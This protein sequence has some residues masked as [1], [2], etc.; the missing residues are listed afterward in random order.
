VSDPAEGNGP[1]IEPPSA[2]SSSHPSSARSSFL[3]GTGILSSKLAGLVRQ[4]VF[5]AFFSDSAEADAFNAAFRIPNILQNLLGEGVLSASFIPVYSRLRARGEDEARRELA[6]ATFGILSLL[7]AVVV[8]CGMLA[9]PVLV[10]VIAG[11]FDE[12]RRALTV[13]LVRIFFPGAGLFVIAAWCLGVLNS[14]GKFFLS[15]AAPVIWNVVMIATLLI[16]GR[17]TSLAPL[18]IYLALGS[19]LGALLQVL[20][21][22]PN[23]SAALGAWRISL[24]ARSPHVRTVLRSFFP[25]FVGRGVNQISGYVDA[26]IASFLVV[27]SVS[28]LSYAQVLYMLPASLFGMAVSAAELPAMSSLSGDDAEV[29]ARLRARLQAGLRRI[30]FFIVP[31]AA[32]FIAFGDLVARL[33]YQ[34]GRFGAAQ[35]TWVWGVLAGASVGLLA[36]TLGRLYASTLYALRDTRTPVRYALI[37]VGVTI[38]LGLVFALWLPGALGIDRQWAVAGLTSSAGIAAWIEFVL[39]RG[40]V[41][42]RVGP[43]TIPITTLGTLW[44]AAGASAAAAWGIRLATETLPSLVAAGLTLAAFGVSYGV[45]TLLLGVPEAKSLLARVRRRRN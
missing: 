23:V 1:G 22:W 36:S 12:G 5:A 41:I 13:T 16:F 28:I 40:A 9:A 43:A 20:M 44:G 38:A 24:G 32:V 7:V 19:V 33:L 14:H 4:R 8:L 15:Y 34:G 26:Y 29:A 42:R 27:G 17:S 6:G 30:A 35:A 21:Q 18:A 37:R 3:V 10:D 2:Q 25:V 11:G 31:S 39:L 45:V